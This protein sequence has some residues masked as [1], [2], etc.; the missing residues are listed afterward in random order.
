MSPFAS[1]YHI[2]NQAAAEVT[3][4][5]VLLNISICFTT[6]LNR[7]VTLSSIKLNHKKTE[8]QHKVHYKRE[9]FITKL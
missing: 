9:F 6:V 1:S 4:F 7:P 3:I 5:S 8:E 2:I